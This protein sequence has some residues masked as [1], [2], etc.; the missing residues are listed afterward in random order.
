MRTLCHDEYGRMHFHKV[1]AGMHLTD[2][3]RPTVFQ[4][5]YHDTIASKHGVRQLLHNGKLKNC[6]SGLFPV[7]EMLTPF[8]TNAN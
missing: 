2:T 1:E 5:S 7:G 4:F 3:S 6:R 8:K